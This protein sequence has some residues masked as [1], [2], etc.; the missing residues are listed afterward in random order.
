MTL[1]RIK[2]VPGSSRCSVD[3]W[4][5]ESLKIRVTARPEKGRANEAVIA[6][7]ADTLRIS[8]KDISISSGAESSRKVIKI[9]QLDDSEICSRLPGR[10]TEEDGPAKGRVRWHCMGSDF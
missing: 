6:L 4:L 8:K 5:G 7:L 1:L 3:G 2:V 9:S 10:Q